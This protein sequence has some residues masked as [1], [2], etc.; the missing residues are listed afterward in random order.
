MID[1]Y[2]INENQKFLDSIKPIQMNFLGS[3]NELPDQASLGD[4]CVVEDKIYIMSSSWTPVEEH[5]Y[6]E[7]SDD[8]TVRMKY[9]KLTCDGCG[10]SIEIKDKDDITCQYCG[11]KYYSK[12]YIKDIE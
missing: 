6:E 11:S 4:V 8:P 1:G 3:Y 5:I 10:A 12:Y 2:I 9:Y 7:K